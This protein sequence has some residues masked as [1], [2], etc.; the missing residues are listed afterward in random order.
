MN[1]W[2]ISEVRDNMMKAFFFSTG[3]KFRIVFIANLGLKKIWIIFFSGFLLIQRSNFLQ[4]AA[5][6]YRTD[7]QTKYIDQIQL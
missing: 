1:D 7:L 6:V 4:S 3:R 2:D 5:A